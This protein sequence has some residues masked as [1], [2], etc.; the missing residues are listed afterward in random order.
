VVLLLL[1]FSRGD[2]DM[3]MVAGTLATPHLIPYNYVVV[4]PAIARVR[5]WLAFILVVISWLP[6]SANWVGDWG[7][8]M[9]HIFSMILWIALFQQRRRQQKL[10]WQSNN[11][12]S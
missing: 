8:H 9:G 3:L 10:I 12:F 2:M 7:W 5:Q 1:W 6:L 11:P 4:L